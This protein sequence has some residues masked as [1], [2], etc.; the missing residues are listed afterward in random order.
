MSKQPIVQI[1]FTLK[2]NMTMDILERKLS[3]TKQK[4]DKKYKNGYPVKSC[5]LNR[6]ICQ[7]LGIET[8]VPDL[9]ETIFGAD[10]YECE[11]TETTMA[12]A[13]INMKKHRRQLSRKADTLVVLSETELT[14]VALE[15]QLFTEN[16]VMIV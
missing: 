13:K 3:E 11:L 5:H 8:T 9:F 6:A 2:N 12:E 7:D 1:C 4:L 14:N 15:I 16:H 10:G